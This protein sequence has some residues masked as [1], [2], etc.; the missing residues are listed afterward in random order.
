MMVHCALTAKTGE[1]N[2]LDARTGTDTR[3]QTVLRC[4]RGAPDVSRRRGIGGLPL[5]LV[6]FRVLAQER[7]EQAKED[8][9]T[10]KFAPVPGETEF[11]PLP[12]S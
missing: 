5:Y 4:A 3:R 12:E 1:C 11:I 2:E 8:W 10:G 7:I 6:E 9:K